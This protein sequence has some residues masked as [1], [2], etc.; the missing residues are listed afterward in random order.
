M[1]HYKATSEIIKPRGFSKFQN[2]LWGEIYNDLWGK[3]VMVVKKTFHKLSLGNVWFKPFNAWCPLKGHAY[4][5]K[6]FSGNERLKVK[7]MK[8]P[9]FNF[10][11]CIWK[12]RTILNDIHSNSPVFNG[13]LPFWEVVSRPPVWSWNLPFWGKHLQIFNFF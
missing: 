13:R 7:W 1:K 5:N 8:Y 2:V 6:L 10:S 4:S 11:V 3:C 12:Y 9:M